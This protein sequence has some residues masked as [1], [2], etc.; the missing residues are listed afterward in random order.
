MTNQIHK[1]KE[2]RDG[3]SFA[4]NGEDTIRTLKIKERVIGINYT[5]LISTMTIEYAI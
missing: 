1:K 3:K 5:L 2:Y 4:V